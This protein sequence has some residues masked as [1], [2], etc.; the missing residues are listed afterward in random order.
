MAVVRGW[1]CAAAVKPNR[2]VRHDAISRRSLVVL[3]ALSTLS[4]GACGLGEQ[5]MGSVAPPAERNAPQFADLST[6][7]RALEADHDVQFG[8]YAYDP[9]SGR[10]YRWNADVRYP[11]CSTVKV[12]TVAAILRLAQQGQLDLQE[13]VPVHAADIVPNSP[14]AYDSVG[15]TMSW[16]ELG[17]AAL[18]RSD[19]AAANLLTRRLGGP[20]VVTEFARSVGDTETRLDRWEPALNEGAPGDPRDT[21]TA[22]ALATGYQRVILGDALSRDYRLMLTSWMRS[23][24]TSRERMRKYLPPGWVAADKTGTGGYGTA[25]DAGV[26]WGPTGTSLVLVIFSRSTVGSAQAEPSNAALARAAR[27]VVGTMSR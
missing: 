7:L 13:R 9:G 10:E 3:L 27:V 24:T 15:E 26:V 22:H 5:N 2:C 8:I 6:S 20:H 14:V 18:V 19:N 23:S 4:A 16:Y 17:E 1:V 12:Y 11:L 21:G 25:N